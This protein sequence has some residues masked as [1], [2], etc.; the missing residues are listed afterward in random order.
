M[1][2]LS[3]P[4]GDMLTRMRN[5]QHARKLMCSFP[6]SKIK[7]QLC[8]LLKAEGYL[9]AVEVT[10]EEPKQQIE[11]TFVK[12]RPVLTLKRISKP[13]RRAYSPAAELKPVL[14]GYGMAVITTS[15]GL[16]TD[17]NARKKKIGGEVLCTIS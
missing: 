8:E 9:E 14:H 13:G 16:M 5:A 7:L 17:K 3:D 4:I 12:D 10:G 6:H 15:E 2:N 11:V 1:T